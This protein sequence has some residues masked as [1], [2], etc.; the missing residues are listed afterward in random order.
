[1]VENAARHNVDRGWITIET[2]QSGAVA[3]IRVAN[4]GAPLDPADVDA[5]FDRFHRSD[6]ARSRS[7]PGFGLGLSIVAAVADAHHAHVAAEALPDG[8][9][10]VTVEFPAAPAA[11]TTTAGEAPDVGRLPV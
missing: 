3:S 1:L 5:L 11:E 7:A 6:E 4:S 8:G 10:A 2:G 9:L